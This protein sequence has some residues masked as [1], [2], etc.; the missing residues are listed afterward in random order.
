MSWRKSLLTG[1]NLVLNRMGLH[2]LAQHEYKAIRSEYR[3]QAY[4][5]PELPS[6]ILEYL[7]WEN[8]ALVELQH[9]YTRHPAAAHTQWS[10]E[11]LRK[12]IDLKNFRADNHYVYQTRW[13]PHPAVYHLTAFYVRGIDRLGLFGKLTE[14][15]LFGTYTLKFEQEY[16]ISRDLLDSINQ[17]NVIAR[18]LG[19]SIVDSF[20]LL[21]IGAG[22]GRLAH[23]LS[24]GF[25]NVRITCTDAVPLSTF[26]SDFY[27]K[28][29]GV[30]KKTEVVPLDRVER[31]LK[32]RRFDIVTNIH[33]F[34]ECPLRAISWWLELLTTVEVRKMLVVPNAPDRF[35]STEADGRHLDFSRLFPEHGWR[36]AHSE[37]IYSASAVA[38]SSALYPRARFYLFER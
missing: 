25:P 34:S 9:R 26:L 28:F 32:S 19:V 4:E 6:N 38:Q 35:L 36:L 23:R 2:V 30:E 15:G 1:A 27:L 7:R 20:D 8:P 13:N 31:E 3:G 22:Y 17:A 11:I 18:F 33:S 21:D 12:E 37:P 5:S 24:E 14:D 16:Q 29:R 10:S